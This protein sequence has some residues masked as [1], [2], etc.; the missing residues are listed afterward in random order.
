MKHTLTMNDRSAWPA[1]A[2]TAIALLGLV[3]LASAQETPF[4]SANGLLTTLG[5]E[6]AYER[7]SPTKDPVPVALPI[8]DDGRDTDLLPTINELVIARVADTASPIGVDILDER[9]RVV[10]TFQWDAGAQRTLPVDLHSLSAGR[11]VAHIRGAAQVSAL[12]FRK[13]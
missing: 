9:G 6:Q 4:A 5:T 13:P 10:R 3:G 8:S 2:A 7:P 11:Y 12:R 1:W